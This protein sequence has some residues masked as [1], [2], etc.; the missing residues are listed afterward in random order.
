VLSA[1][2]EISSGKAL[3]LYDS[4]CIAPHFKYNI[5]PKN[6]LFVRILSDK[7]KLSKFLDCSNKSIKD[8]KEFY[9]A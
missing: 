9:A 4:L 6:E 3:G 2:F 7:N 5:N 8:S 1:E